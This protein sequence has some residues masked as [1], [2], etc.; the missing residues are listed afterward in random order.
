MMI[1][2][3][4]YVLSKHVLMKCDS[5]KSLN[6]SERGLA[7]C[8]RAGVRAAGEAQRNI[9]KKQ[10]RK[11]IKPYFIKTCF[12][13]T[14][15]DD[16]SITRLS[17]LAVICWTRLSGPCGRLK[18]LQGMMWPGGELRPWLQKMVLALKTTFFLGPSKIVAA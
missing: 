1:I 3:S 2:S 9:S 14:Y 17:K 8:V 10:D 12:D 18:W 7:A 11:F 5:M 4:K 6:A 16:Y 13:E 15:L